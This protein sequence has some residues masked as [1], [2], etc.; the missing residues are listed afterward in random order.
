[1]SERVAVK[2]VSGALHDLMTPEENV[3]YDDNRRR[4]ME[5]YRFENVAD[6]QDLDRLLVLELL[7]YRYG[8]WLT[9]GQDYDGLEFESSEVRNAKKAF[10]QE[11]RLVKKHMGMDRKGRVESESQSVSDYLQ[12]LLRRAEEFGVHRDDQI[13]SAINLI[14]ELKKMVGLYNRCDEEERHH[15]GVEL[16]DIFKW[17]E[18][19]LIPSYDEVDKAFRKNQRLWIKEIS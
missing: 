1:M 11:I 5:E 10:D 12:G 19:V 4:Y 17:V 16:V 13:A 3:W 14:N 6:L 2:G 7:S 15:L 8:S 9:S 18:T